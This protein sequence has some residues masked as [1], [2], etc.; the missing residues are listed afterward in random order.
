[1]D[2]EGLERQKELQLKALVEEHCTVKQIMKQQHQAQLEFK[3]DELSAKDALISTKSSTI[4]SLQVKLGQALGISSRKDNLSVFSPGVKLT[5]T[6]YA[7]LPHDISS[8]DR[9]VVIDGNIY[10]GVI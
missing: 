9:G 8:H 1:M 3:I 2:R 6:E 4:Q 7:K 5:F 10:I